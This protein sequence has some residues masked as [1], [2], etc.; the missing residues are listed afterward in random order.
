[1]S[2]EKKLEA[3]IE[4]IDAKGVPQHLHAS[5]AKKIYKV[6]GLRMR[7]ELYNSFWIVFF[8]TFTISVPLFAAIWYFIESNRGEAGPDFL[9]PSVLFGLLTSGLTYWFIRV[10]AKTYRLCQWEEL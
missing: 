6:L 9:L 8:Q 3:A 2:F 7:P 10:R 5:A 4:E 1:M